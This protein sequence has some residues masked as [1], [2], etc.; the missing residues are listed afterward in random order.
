MTLP[1]LTNQ[2]GF[3]FIGEITSTR[4]LL[5]YG[6]K[7][8]REGAFFDTT[9]DPIFTMLSIGVEKHLKLVLGVLSVE[10]AGRWATK[11]EM[12]SYGHG[13]AEMWDHVMDK[14]SERTAG[15]S[16]YLR[17]LVAG[18][19]ADPVL[20][21][22]LE[23]LDRYGRSGRFYNLDLLGDTPQSE[24]APDA[25]FDAV[26]QAAMAD[27]EVAATYTAAMADV[28]GQD[29]WDTFYATLRARIA[30]SVEEAWEM[31]SR[32]GMHGVFGELGKFMGADL[33]ADSVGRQ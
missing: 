1:H 23:V 11:S 21:P 25:M 5:G 32:L 2:Q 24:L 30:R 15:K 33:R 6:L 10:D 3:A 14:V 20:R 7:A 9:R 17:G 12:K 19:D 4:N 26:E 27:P 13:I 16:D 22:L 31:L 28:S 29:A 8:L 18:V